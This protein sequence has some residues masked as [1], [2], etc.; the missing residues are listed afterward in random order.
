MVRRALTG[1]VLIS[2]VGCAGSGSS[3]GGSHPSRSTTT[4]APGPSD[5][6]YSEA[7]AGVYD[8]GHY[9]IGLRY[10]PDQPAI[11]ATTTI[12]ATAKRNLAEFHLDFSG[13]TIDQITV[14]AAAAGLSRTRTDLTVRPRR[15]IASGATFVTKIRYHGV[16]R[17]I[18]DP[19]DASDDPTRI[20]W[21]RTRDGR[22]YVVSEPIG[23]RT[24]FPGNDHP[25]D[26]ATF[27]IRVDVPD[28][29]SVASNGTFAP[30]PGSPGRYTWHWTMAQPMATYLATV[31]IA[32]MREEQ[33]ASAAGV[34]IRNFFPPRLYDES[35]TDF[36]TTGAMIDYFS[37]IFGPY[38]FD[39]YGA[40]VLR[41]E[42]GYALET[43][44]MSI[45]GSDMLGTDQD[46][47][48]TVA[49]EL[50]HQWF[51]D[52]VSIRRWA[53]IWLN[54]GFATYA[55]Y[56]WDDHVDPAFDIN[57]EMAKLR[58]GDE[59]HLTRPHNPGVEG[60]FSAA[61]YERGALTLH[62]LRLT[63]GDAKFFELVKVWTAK[64]RYAN[65]TTADFI[66]LTNEIAG[67]DLT[68]F[69]HRWLDTNQVPPLPKSLL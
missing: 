43:Q 25:A 45:F 1:L 52:S 33:T 35:V 39:A 62:A 23:A 26:K 65:A 10:S 38:P 66:A 20:G 50:A 28:G 17:A 41:D 48:D 5:P 30:T 37:T 12:T 31:V 4:T 68:D 18:A 2:L 49:H 69:F 53:D 40:V 13:L 9:D 22:V 29:V 47:E 67:Q 59:R 3:S 8:V 58:A 63:I 61:T 54:E 27:D 44:T 32:P 15:A 51:G 34:P 64:Y 56:L 42:I 11:T 60:L 36:A 7:G 46:A 6:Y 55:Q 21:T 19:G 57:L 16:P 14:D 24:W